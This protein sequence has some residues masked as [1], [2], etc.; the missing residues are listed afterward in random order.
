[1]S[2][3]DRARTD[4]YRAASPKKRLSTG[5]DHKS[6]AS[7]VSKLN[8]FL[9][10]NAFRVPELL[11]PSAWHEHAPFAFWLVEKLKPCL[12]VELGTHFGFSYFSFCQAIRMAG[13]N[14]V[15]FAV[16][17]WTGDD[18]AGWYG[19]EVYQQVQAFNLERYSDLSTL[20]KMEFKEAQTH[21]EDGSIDLLHID[22]GHYL[23][24]VK[25]DFESW[26]PKLSDCA[27]VLFHDINVRG[28]GFGVHR[29]WSELCK[30]YPNFSFIH[31]SGLGVLRVGKNCSLD[32]ARWFDVT[33]DGVLATA[34]REVYARLGCSVGLSFRTAEEARLRTSAESS[35]A[36]MTKHAS[37][38]ERLRSEA[39][40]IAERV[41]SD[42][43]ARVNGLQ[44][45]L[46]LSRQ[47][48]ELLGTERA[49]LW[50]R[51][52]DLS[53][54]G[55][56]RVD[57]E[58]TVA[59]LRK[60]LGVALTAL[61]SQRQAA[62]EHAA[63]RTD[64]EKDLSRAQEERAKVLTE[65]HDFARMVR[66]LPEGLSVLRSQLGEQSTRITQ[67]ENELAGAL[68][69]AKA[70]IEA[71]R[72]SRILRLLKPARWLVAR[73]RRRSNR[74]LIAR[75]SLFDREWYLR[76]Y[77][78]VKTSGIDPAFH[79]LQHGAGEGR[80]PSPLFDSDWYLQQYPDVKA[81][82]V[83]PLVH[84][85]LRGAAEGRKPGPFL[86][87]R[88]PSQATDVS[89]PQADYS[90]S[91]SRT[92][93]EGHSQNADIR[94][95]SH[96]RKVGVGIL[97]GY[98]TFHPELVRGP[99]LPLQ[100]SVS[101]VI[102][103]YNG[104]TEFYWLIRKIH[105]QR[106]LRSIEIIIVDSGSE[107]ATDC[108]AEELGCKLIRIP[109]TQFSH[110]VSRNRGAEE[111]T[112]DLLL[113]MV[114]DAHPV[115]DYWLH[116]LASMLLQSEHGLAAVSCAEFSRCDSEL[117]YD[118]LIDTHYRFLGCRSGDRIGSFISNSQIDLRKQGQ[119]SNVA[120]LIRRDVFEQY[121][122]VG[123]YA[124]DLTLG[125]RLIRDGRRI[126]MVSSIPIIHAHRRSAG[127]YLRRVFAD[128][129]FL[130][131]VFPDYAVPQLLSLRGT[132]AV[133]FAFHKALPK[134]LGRAQLTPGNALRQAITKLGEMTL[135][136]TSE[137]FG[138]SDFGYPPFGQWVTRVEQKARDKDSTSVL[139]SMSIFKADYLARLSGLVSNVDAIYPMLDEHLASK[140]NDAIEK[141]LTMTLGA[142]LA[143]H[144]LTAKSGASLD[145]EPSL[146]LELENL[147]LEGV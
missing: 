106:G 117:L 3:K 131:G 109:K 30:E 119:L 20:L 74:R 113:F 7:D 34:I 53:D 104:G 45:S 26:L 100:T 33:A 124:E 138:G 8:E 135:P 80:N 103:T 129:I 72:R 70:E 64:L 24:D 73:I 36:E 38:E 118:M 112:G 60:D 47:Q 2:G 69:S 55:R 9:S 85:L 146:V 61:S 108:T 27:V 51:V 35:L 111:A 127:Y 86:S 66:G 114:Q 144:T 77:G 63:R 125:I 57:A 128:A 90:Y 79:Y 11:V 95:G 32:I 68:Q 89:V 97:P 13:L 147:L 25:D 139:Q 23:T 18:H 65:L 82:G 105:Q 93:Q 76:T 19:D 10:I 43:E 40:A 101:V 142:Q 44:K 31:G 140:L 83:N 15:A 50:R 121:K 102:P 134:V 126:A 133:A 132:L 84:Y 16:D 116:G 87:N 28:R 110:S 122:F 46:E 41:R 39:E 115:G 49:F 29:F 5:S 130:T 136:I 14:T 137:F 145:T 6:S 67:L 22:G 141:T 48:V 42:G 12:F 91:I 123:R 62:A 99:K 4:L 88:A 78:D 59:A 120:C 56:L 94:S 107:D 37:E 75:S 92:C 71:L 17:R 58:N 1:M 54:Q 81:A 52:T 96:L 143:F 21:F 98:L